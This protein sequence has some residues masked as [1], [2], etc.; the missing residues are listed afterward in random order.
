M[1]EE[2]YKIGF[3]WANIGKLLFFSFLVVLLFA[4][5]LILFQK[6]DQSAQEPIVDVNY[7]P[8]NEELKIDDIV[9]GSGNEV[10]DGDKVS[11]HYKGSLTNGTE[12]DSSYSR[13]QPF[14]FSVGMGE[15][16]KGWDVGLVGMKVGG[17]RKLTIPSALGYGEQGAGDDIPPNSTLIFE[18][19][20]LE[21]K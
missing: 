2:N 8:M 6:K 18:V 13:N 1:R 4:T 19:E 12:F 11:V 20:L 10:K 15:V 17:K 16:I 21:I 14:E 7:I 3:N 5:A 9:V